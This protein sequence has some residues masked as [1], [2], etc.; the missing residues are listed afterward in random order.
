MSFQ[1]QRWHPP[2]WVLVPLKNNLGFLWDL[3]TLVQ[4]MVL[5][6]KV[7]KATAAEPSSETDRPRMNQNFATTAWI[8]FPAKL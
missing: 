4:K 5:G 3:V 1:E 7:S 6:R 8:S 2:A